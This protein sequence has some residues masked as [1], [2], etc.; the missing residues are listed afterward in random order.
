MHSSLDAMGPLNNR[1]VDRFRMTDTRS[2]CDDEAVQVFDLA[3][4]V[5]SSVLEHVHWRL[6]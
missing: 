2:S 5:L 4:A 1:C 3:P 6:G